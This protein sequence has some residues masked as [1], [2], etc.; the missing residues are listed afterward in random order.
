MGGSHS[1]SLELILAGTVESLIR[2]PVLPGTLIGGPDQF[3]IHGSE[4]PSPASPP[5]TPPP[6][7]RRSKSVEVPMLRSHSHQ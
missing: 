7:W 6:T 4:G 3:A 1:L 5:L 2:H